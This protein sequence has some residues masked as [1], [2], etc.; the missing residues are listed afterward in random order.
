VALI[1]DEEIEATGQ[2]YAAARRATSGGL[3]LGMV[4]SH[5]AMLRVP[6]LGQAWREFYREVYGRD[7]PKRSH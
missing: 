7:G 3:G 2:A 1:S 4:N 5:R 6:A